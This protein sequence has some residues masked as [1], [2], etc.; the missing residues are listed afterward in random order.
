MGTSG[1]EVEEDVRADRGRP[2]LGGGVANGIIVD[3]QKE[4]EE[5]EEEAAR[6]ERGRCP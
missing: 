4:E 1:E 5:E 3:G 2:C 6:A